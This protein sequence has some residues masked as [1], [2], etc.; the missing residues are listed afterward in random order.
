MEPSIKKITSH[1]NDNKQKSAGSNVTQGEDMH[2]ASQRTSKNNKIN[3][4][5]KRLLKN[6]TSKSDT[7]YRKEDFWLSYTPYLFDEKRWAEAQEA[8]KQIVHFVEES[9]QKHVDEQKLSILDACC[10]PGRFSLEFARLG[11]RVTAV[12]IV[13]SFLDAIQDTAVTE[14]LPITTV[15][16]DILALN[17]KNT[18]DIALNLYTS[19]G[20]FET[21]DDDFALLKIIQESLK[22]GGWFFLE[23][24]SKE[25]CARYYSSGEWFE[26]ENALICTQF[27]VD[28]GWNYL[29]NRWIVCKDGHIT[30]NTWNLRLYA[31]TELKEMLLKAGF[32]DIRSYGSYTFTPYN[33]DA[34]TLLVVAR[35]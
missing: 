28:D 30:D 14:Q 10:G 16:K 7:W 22:P 32:A 23:L 3:K 18:F 9:G 8:T 25:M 20:Y 13:Q 15:C 33:N 29:R 24:L 34:Q 27:S 19:F 35:K 17:A 21:K 6:N 5:K 4:T 31:F 1:N 12:D 26:K 11:H 2:S